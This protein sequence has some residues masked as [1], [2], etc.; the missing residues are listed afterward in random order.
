MNT[1]TW[2][3]AINPR[4]ELV[5]L[6]T[7]ALEICWAYGFFALALQASGNGQ[8]GVSVFTFGALVLAAIYST[9]FMLNTTLPQRRKQSISLALALGSIALALRATFFSNYGVFDLSWLGQLPSAIGNLF[10]AFSPVALLLIMGA[11]A[12][13]RGL[14]LAQGSFDFEGVGFRFRL[15][16]LMLALLVLL[17][18]WIARLDIGGLLVA[19]FF[20]G[21]LAVALA[22]QEDVGRSES[23]VSLPLKGPWL[24]ILVGSVMLVLGLAALL[25]L[26][27]TPQGVRAI[28]DLFRPLEPLVVIILYVLLLLISY[29][30][31]FIYALITFFIQRFINPNMQLPPLALPQRPPLDTAQ[32][33]DD[34][35]ALAMFW[36]PLRTI[37]AVVLVGGVLLLLALSLNNMQKRNRQRGNETRE[38]V[39]VS[40]DLNPFKRLRDW[41]RRPQFQFDESDVASIR[42]IYANLVRLAAERGYPRR[43]AE[44]PYEFMRDL[45]EAFP[46]VVPEERAIT[47]AY[48]RV[49]YGERSPTAEEM[50]Q[51]RDAWE[52][53]KGVNSEQ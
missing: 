18:T 9:R 10:I 6:T 37:C 49:H 53:I 2:R 32:H 30:I 51:V 50:Q 11:Y 15:G 43:E 27:L 17:N 23:A 39:P 52:R 31:E 8:R 22:R 41:L 48:V 47:E 20:F 26:V 4:F 34:F 46:E 12:W 28:F 16:V 1:I 40:L 36:D 14:S 13:W 25:A 19:F 33:P 45:R 42:R 44:T 5:M 21:L 3:D 7:A 38:S 35:A 24:G 29:V